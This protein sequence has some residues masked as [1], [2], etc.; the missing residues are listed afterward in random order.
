MAHA[1]LVR[2]YA[3]QQAGARRRTARRAVKL[4]VADAARGKCVEI[5]CGD[6]AAVRADVGP[7]HV[8]DENDDDVG[9]PIGLRGRRR[10]QYAE[11]EHTDYRGR[12][13]AYCQPGALGETDSHRNLLNRWRKST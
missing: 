12:G 5:W 6:L 2:V 9:S 3:S 11:R 13:D 8:V 4:A 10:A 7:S 1:G